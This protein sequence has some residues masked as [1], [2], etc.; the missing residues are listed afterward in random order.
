MKAWWLWL[1]LWPAWQ[2]AAA[3]KVTLRGEPVALHVVEA[4]S[5]DGSM[6]LA[7]VLWDGERKILVTGSSRDRAAVAMMAAL[8]KAEIADGDNETIT[9]NCTL[10]Q[11]ASTGG[12]LRTPGARHERITSLEIEG[13]F[14]RQDLDRRLT[15]CKKCAFRLSFGLQ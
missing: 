2:T 4:M 7:L 15:P 11:V 6:Q 3:Q 8:I 13:H 1:L 9:V 14:S 10:R 5:F 12:E